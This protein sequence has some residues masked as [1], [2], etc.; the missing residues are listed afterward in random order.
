MSNI[1]AISKDSFQHEVLDS[2]LPVIVD[3]WADW[4]GP[5]RMFATV[6]D[7]IAEAYQNDLKVVKVNVDEEPELSEKYE[8]MTIPTLALIVNGQ[9]VDTVS[10]AIPQLKVEEWLQ[11]HSIFKERN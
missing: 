10:G 11:K 1:C 9:T 7:A 5:C 3:F 6:I 8:V 4:C 2:Q